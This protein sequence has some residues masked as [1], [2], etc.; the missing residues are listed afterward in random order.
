MKFTKGKTVLIIIVGIG[1]FFALNLF[2]PYNLFAKVNAEN[3]LEEPLLENHF[4]GM[5]VQGITY[6]GDNTYLVKTATD[7]YIVI[8]DYFSVMNYKW[9]I[10]EY[11][12]TLAY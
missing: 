1:L 12:K 7:E 2:G 6:Q 3:I 4:K 9:K 11:D 10:Y 5:D 8:Q